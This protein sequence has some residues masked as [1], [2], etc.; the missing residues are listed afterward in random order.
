VRAL[1]GIEYY[2]VVTLAYQLAQ[3]GRK[4][5]FARAHRT[6]ER[7]NALAI[8]AYPIVYAVNKRAFYTVYIVL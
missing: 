2:V 3:L 7:E 5:A 4:E 6:E 8:T 1:R